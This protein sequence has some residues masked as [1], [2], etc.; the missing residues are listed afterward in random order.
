MMMSQW[1]HKGPDTTKRDYADMTPHS[2][3]PENALNL[4][5]L[6]KARK[7]ELKH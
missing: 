5:T 6:A 3:D 2:L 7:A 4:P 1:H